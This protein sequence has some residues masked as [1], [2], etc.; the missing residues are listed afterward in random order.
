MHSIT[1]N[2]DLPLQ[3]V[4]FD[5]SNENCSLLHFDLTKNNIFINSKK[6]ITIID[7]DDAKYGNSICDV[8]IFIANL[9]FSKTRGVDLDGMKLFLNEYYN[10]DEKKVSSK[11]TEIKEYA[12]SWIDYILSGNEFDTSTNE[13]F[14]VR[15]KL[16]QKYL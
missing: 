5:K 15:K 7:F 14:E 13:S 9:F 4:K 6:E 2:I 3:R 16:I 1:K 8:A 10:N 11:I 12:T